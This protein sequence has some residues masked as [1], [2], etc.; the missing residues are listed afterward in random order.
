[1]KK[2]LFLGLF[3]YLAALTVSAEDFYI[4][5]SCGDWH[6]PSTW[7]NGKVPTENDNVIIEGEIICNIAFVCKNL[8]IEKDA[9]LRINCDYSQSCIVRGDA[10]NKGQIFIDAQSTIEFRRELQNLNIFHNCG[11]IELL[12]Y[13]RLVD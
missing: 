13:L 6:S 8:T 1:M 3:L 9:I 10:V 4:K 5:D 2:V 7:K 12:N 11:K